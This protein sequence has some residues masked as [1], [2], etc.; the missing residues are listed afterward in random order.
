[1]KTELLDKDARRENHV[2]FGVSKNLIHLKS[3]ASLRLRQLRT[4]QILDAP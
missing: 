2:T 1:M 4:L 3:Q